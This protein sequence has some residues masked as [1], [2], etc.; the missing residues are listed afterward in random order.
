[1]AR[2]LTS[3]DWAPGITGERRAASTAGGGT[4]CSTTAAYATVPDGTVYVRM[5]PRNFSTA[6]VVKWAPCPYLAVLITTDSLATD[7]DLSETVQDGTSGTVELD[8]LDTAANGGFLFVGSHVPFRGV[9]VDV[10]NVN[11]T[12]SVLTVNY[13]NG[14]TWTDTSDTDGTSSGGATF[15]QDGNV[16]WTVPSGW[17]KTTLRAIATPVPAS[18]TTHIDTP[19]YWTRWEVSV[20]LDSDTTVAGML[21]MPASTAYAELPTGESESFRLSKNVGGFSGVEAVTDAGTANLIVNAM[22]GPQGNF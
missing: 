11:G 15:A 9:N 2:V 18:S 16:T 6:V 17:L 14:T 19:L 8:S 12:S 22:T 13:W 4:A 10:T 20:Q 5:F 7:T 1:M 21:G 3:G